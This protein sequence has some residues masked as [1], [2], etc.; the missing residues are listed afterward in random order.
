[1]KRKEYSAGAVKMPFWFVE[2]RKAVELLSEGKN[3]LQIKNLAMN[4]NLFAAPTSLRAN[5]IFSTVTG[6]I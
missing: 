3:Y 4:E 6:R 2:F 5:Q 1:M